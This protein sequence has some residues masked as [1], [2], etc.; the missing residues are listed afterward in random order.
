MSKTKTTSK[1]FMPDEFLHEEAIEP[2]Q[3]VE[4][5]LMIEKQEPRHLK[6]PQ[7][8]PAT[9][10]EI[11]KQWRAIRHFFRTGENPN[12]V[13]VAGLKP[14]LLAH[15]LNGE[16]PLTDYPLFLSEEKE[17]EHCSFSALLKNIFQ[18][19]FKEGEAGILFNNLQRI[20]NYVRKY[21]AVAGNYCS[22]N[23]VFEPALN[24]LSKIK[25]KGDDRINFLKDIEKFKSNFPETGIL[26]GFSQQTP[27]H[28]LV[29][30]LKHQSKLKRNNFIAEL[31]SVKS[32]LEDLLSVEKIK[33]PK[34]QSSKP[35][36]D[37]AG[38]LI[39]FNTLETLLPESAS[40]SMPQKRF[41]R[42]SN[43]IRVLAMAENILQ[44]HDAIIYLGKT[45]ADNQ[46]YNWKELLHGF[47]LRIAE[48]GQSCSAASAGFRLHIAELSKLITAARVARLEVNNKYD[49]EIHDDYFSRFNWSYFT[50][51]ETSLCPPI[52]LVEE[53]QNLLGNE[54]HHFSALI[55]SNKPVKIM[56]VN[57]L[58]PNKINTNGNESDDLF[59]FQQE[60]SVLAVS[61]RSAFTL[62]TAL[63]NPMH[64]LNGFAAGLS[65]ASPALLHVLV[66]SIL[67]DS[68]TQ[69]F[70]E[71]SSAVEGRQFPLFTY[72]TKGEKWGSRFNINDNPQPYRN[73]PE[74]FFEFKNE[75]DVLEK[76]ELDF[77]FA[78][79]IALNKVPYKN[80]LVVLPA[81]WSDDLIPL[82]DYLELSPEQ[83]YSKVP[84]IWLA[85]AENIL[86]KA[87]VPFSLVIAAKERLD[88][89]N[90]IQELGGV[91]SF[92]VEQAI[93][94]TRS[95]MQEQKEKEI[96]EI[97]SKFEKQIE[98]VRTTATGEAMN[99]LAGILLDLDRI[100]SLP[101][102]QKFSS[103][104]L[105]PANK[106]SKS[107]ENLSLKV[108]AAEK[109]EEVSAEPWVD[110]V[111]CT[112]CNECTDKYPR[113]FKY[114]SDKQAYVDDPTTVT[115]AQLIKATEACP[116]KCIHPGLPMNPNEPGLQ[117]LIARAKPFN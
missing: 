87:A 42:I 1:E 108:E 72:N 40:E 73:W 96:K 95:E 101:A 69:N 31:H 3:E 39:E 8:V 66:N 30:L 61:Q 91:N 16:E 18:K 37:F 15:F 68:I 60:L 92:H 85:D 5:A 88:L 71:I 35:G 7:A 36:I 65:S 94:R 111:K 86:H 2:K 51:E 115:Y 26:L 41:E 56:A 17:F 82:S 79:Y 109:E 103:P 19:T 46:N 13:E 64:M 93:A 104:S 12:P 107:P 49:D 23:L 11:K 43:C 57:R 102:P 99:H 81:C 27:V 48:A 29:H 25:I 112:S 117:E 70:F 20:E 110:S 62:Q 34:E 84:F 114:N 75:H 55:A 98:E 105:T 10:A 106:E 78:D 52:V 9:E 22:L 59:S 67:N 100:T 33:S 89:W 44:K 50:E 90:F 74:Y 32:G 4:I 24:E 97:E 14:A 21:V 45:L 77:T 113:A 28:I 63:H 76:S 58:L 80:L 47:D 6:L 116:A 83:L 54:L 38:E 53:T